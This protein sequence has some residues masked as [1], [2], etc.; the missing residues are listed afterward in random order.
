MLNYESP[1]ERLYGSQPRLTHLRTIGCLFFCQ[2]LVEHDKMM[3]RSKSTVHMGYSKTQKG[4]VLFDLTTKIFFISRDV[5]FREDIFPFS[6][7]KMPERHILF[8]NP[9]PN[10]SVL[11]DNFTNQVFKTLSSINNEL[12]CLKDTFVLPDVENTL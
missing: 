6:Q 10:S 12:S 1:Y 11:F 2:N 5:I 4:C 8:Q 7:I 3:T 9:L